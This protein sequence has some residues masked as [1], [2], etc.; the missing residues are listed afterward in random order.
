MLTLINLPYGSSELQFAVPTH[1]LVG[2]FSPNQVQPAADPARE[3]QHALENPIG[4]GPLHLAARGAKRVVIVADDMTRQTPNP[5][6]VPL[7][8]NELNRAGVSD[9]HISVLIALGTHR[10]MTF[11][12]ISRHFGP[13]VMA[14]VKVFNHQWQDPS[15]LIDLGCT[16]NGTPIQINRAALEADFLIGLGSIVPHHIPGY[17]GGA[18]I[19]QPGISGAQTTGATHFLSTRTRRSYL[20]LAENPVRSEMEAVA[21]QAGLKF[22]LNVVQ[23]SSGKMIGA[24]AG[25]YVLAHRAGVFLA[26]QVYG[27]T[28]PA[29]VE[30]VLAGSHP[31]DLEFWQAH[32]SLYPADILVKDGG[33][34][35]VV[36]PC[37]EGVS[38]MHPEVL[39]YAGQSAEAIEAQILSGEI[40]DQAAGALALAWAKIRQR[41]Q[42][43]LVSSGIPL[44]AAQALKFSNFNSVQ[45]ALE[46]AFR[47]L[48]T[49]A[50]L[51]I[52]THAP[53]TLPLLLR[54]LLL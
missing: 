39:Q 15:Q 24:F 38:V 45:A 7:I 13:E 44:H 48:S 14:R 32:K 21:D 46:T 54:D 10:E 4:T 42:I 52:L 11:E 33:I 34:I 19:I 40:H 51:A 6:I 18:K 41:A 16:A 49:D 22:I 25:D 26:Q 37:P 20:G 28:V 53:D 23:D 35:I 31:C 29:P 50:R 3:I 47:Q 43:F 1:N 2:I 36:T 5:L 12:E 8:L 30:I 9:Q 27:V 17:S